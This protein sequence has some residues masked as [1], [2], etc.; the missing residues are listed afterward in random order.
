MS[1]PILINL[2]PG[3]VQLF[4]EEVYKWVYI[5]VSEGL[6]LVHQHMINIYV[7]EAEIGSN[8]DFKEAESTYLLAK[9]ALETNTDLEKYPELTTKFKRALARFKYFELVKNIKPYVNTDFSKD[10]V[11]GKIDFNSRI[12]TK[13]SK[14]Y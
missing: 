11:R 5:V 1:N 14:Y 13:Y 9:L 4:D 3:V 6:I 12:D 8:I 10:D 2:E 7:Y